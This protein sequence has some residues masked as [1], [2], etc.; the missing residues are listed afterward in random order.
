MSENNEKKQEKTKNISDGPTGGE[1]KEKEVSMEQ[2][3]K[4]VEDKLL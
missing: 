2:K 1:T 3:L 4:D